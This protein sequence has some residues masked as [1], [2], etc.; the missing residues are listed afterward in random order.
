MSIEENLFHRPSDPA[1]V[2]EQVGIVEDLPDPA[3]RKSLDPLASSLQYSLLCRPIAKKG[4]VA[5]AAAGQRPLLLEKF[6]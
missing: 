5:V 2:H 6:R 4:L 3:A 1:V